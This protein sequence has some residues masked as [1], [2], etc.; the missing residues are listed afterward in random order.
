MTSWKNPVLEGFARRCRT[1]VEQERPEKRRRTIGLPKTPVDPPHPSAFAKAGQTGALVV[2]DGRY[3]PQASPI[4]TGF[5]V[6]SYRPESVDIDERHLGHLRGGPKGP[7]DALSGAIMEEVIFIDV[8]PRGHPEAPLKIIH[9]GIHPS[10]AAPRIVLS[11]PEGSRCQVIELFEPS[12]PCRRHCATDITIGQ[13]ARVGYAR[14]QSEDGGS[15]HYA[16]IGVRVAREGSIRLGSFCLGSGDERNDISIS[17]EGLR[18]EAH[19]H[20]LAHAENGR[21]CDSLCEIVHAAAETRS[22]QLFKSLVG[23]EGRSAFTGRV[24]VQRQA[25]RSDADQLC[26]SLLLSNK[27]HTQAVPELE[28]YADDVKC[29]HG[30]TVGHM[31][32]EE[33]FYLKSRA[34]SEQRALRLLSLAFVSEVIEKAA[35]GPLKRLVEKKMAH[36]DL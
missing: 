2:S 34:I 9:T 11:A 15:L 5:S 27:A 20:A 25:Q 28:V 31:G 33:L 17:L 35:C 13:G 14:I 32:Q 22:R 21:R 24:V 4:P 18:A 29:T 7:L 10:A 19:F 30:A 12:G 26:K 8:A 23:H 1:L 16:N 3:L 36:K 6:R